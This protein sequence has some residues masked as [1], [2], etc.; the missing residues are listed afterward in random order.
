MTG[1]L[2]MML[3]DM[4][5]QQ[6]NTTNGNANPTPISEIEKEQRIY[7]TILHEII[8]QVSVE[9]ADRGILLEKVSRR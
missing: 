3:E 8:R 2:E 7:D 4:S 1:I 5:A 6:L 9:C